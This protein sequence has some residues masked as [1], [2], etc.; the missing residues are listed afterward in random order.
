L[1][2]KPPK[3]DSSSIAAE[4][5]EGQRIRLDRALGPGEF[6]KELAAEPIALLLVPLEG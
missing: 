3:H 1:V 6:G 5:S 4:D 2:R